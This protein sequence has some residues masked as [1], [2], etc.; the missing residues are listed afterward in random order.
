MKKVLLSLIIICISSTV[1]ASSRIGILLERGIMSRI[2]RELKKDPDAIKNMNENWLGL[3]AKILKKQNGAEIVQFAIDNGWDVNGK[4]RSG[5]SALHVAASVNH[6]EIA[7]LLVESGADINAKDNAKK[8]P[9]HSAALTGSS[10]VTEYILNLKDLNG[11][12]KVEIDSLT[13]Q[14][15]TPLR[16]V[17]SQHKLRPTEARKKTILS[18]VEHG[19]ELNNDFGNLDKQLP[20]HLAAKANLP[21]V[22]QLMIDKGADITKLTSTNDTPLEYAVQFG[23]VEAAEVLIKNGAKVTDKIMKIAEDLDNNAM[24]TLLDQ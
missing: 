23:S 14:N 7:K 2:E 11:N 15:V 19:A 4:G 16:L 9:L 21:E 6:L 18:L 8:T 24:M 5:E 12:K 17:I 10:E 3:G 13:K 1:F 22:V 20:L